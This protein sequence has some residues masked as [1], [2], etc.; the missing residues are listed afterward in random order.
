ME[1][2]ENAASPIQG[3]HISWMNA[4]IIIMSLI[5]YILLTITSLHVS[6]TTQASYDAMNDF[7]NCTQLGELFLDGSNY[8]TEQARLYISTTNRTHMDNYFAEVHTAYRRDVALDILSQFEPGEEIY[9]YLQAAMDKSVMLMEQEVY[10]MALVS[11][12]QGFDPQSLP[13]EVQDAALT[14]EDRT[15]PPRELVEKARELVFG[16]EYQSVKVEISDDIEN[17]LYALTDR[18]GQKIEDDYSNLHHAMATHQTLIAVH[19]IGTLVIFAS[20]LQLVVL[21]MRNFVKHIENRTPLQMTGAYEC[22]HLAQTYNKMFAYITANEHML[23]HQAEHDALT[24]LLNRGAFDNLH[25]SLAG[26]EGSLALL[27]VD[28]DK[29]KQINDSYGH[30][31]GDQV[32]KK[33]AQLLAQHFRGTDYPARIGGDEFAV[34][35]MDTAPEE[36]DIIAGKIMEINQLLTHPADGL[37]VVSL[38]VGGAFSGAGFSETLYKDA[39]SALYEVKEHG[40]CGC[41]FYNPASIHT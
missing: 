14:V 27:L 11:L 18:Y 21:P 22:K 39:D 24:G 30:E 40:R 15:L 36:Q 31:T 32:L 9:S 13:Q 10:A 8:L 6:K 29:F 34:I 12:A 37:P 3:I 20:T 26:Y 7:S 35:V 19:F 25:A 38:S 1:N 2:H 33:V 23:R 41:R 4:A 17:L 5:L 16:S 28:V